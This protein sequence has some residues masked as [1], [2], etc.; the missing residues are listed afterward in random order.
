M[1][2]DVLLESEQKYENNQSFKLRLGVTVA[3]LHDTRGFWRFSSKYSS[4]SL[5]VIQMNAGL[6]GTTGNFTIKHS[7]LFRL[8]SPN[9]IKLFY[10]KQIF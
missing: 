6:T 10:F 2:T 3:T 1:V 9:Y 8:L 5:I 7:W 4:L